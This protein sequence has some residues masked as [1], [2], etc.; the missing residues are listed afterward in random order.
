[1]LG[2]IARSVREM[3]PQ[4]VIREDLLDRVRKRRVI[5]GGNEQTGFSVLDQGLKP[6]DA[7]ANDRCS[8]GHG[9]ESDQTERLRE[10]WDGADVGRGVEQ[11]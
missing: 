2:A 4:P 7:R 5:A 8:A 11:R 1:M 10:R 9:L 3:H 6:A